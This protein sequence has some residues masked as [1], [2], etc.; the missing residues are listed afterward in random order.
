MSILPSQYPQKFKEDIFV[1]F[2]LG[3]SAS[4]EQIQHFHDKHYELCFVLKGS[5]DYYFDCRKCNF[6][7]TF[8]SKKGISPREFRKADKI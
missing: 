3:E 2:C 6:C 5:Y 8:K 1:N 7:E 4:R